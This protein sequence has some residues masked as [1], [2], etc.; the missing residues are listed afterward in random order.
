MAHPLLFVHFAVAG[1]AGWWLQLSDHLKPSQ[2]EQQVVALCK[3]AT[4]KRMHC[5]SIYSTKSGSQF[6]RHQSL[7]Q[8]A[9][10][11]WWFKGPGFG[12]GIC[13]K[14]ALIIQTELTMKYFP[15]WLREPR[16]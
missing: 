9:V 4:V 6:Q 11:A 14:V 16:C 5:Q 13:Y 7:H 2:R 3:V 15:S 12:V 1:I 10:M 8:G